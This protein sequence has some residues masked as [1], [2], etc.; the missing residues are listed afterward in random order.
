[1]KTFLLLIAAALVAAASAKSG[2]ESPLFKKHPKQYPVGP[3]PSAIAAA[4]LNDDTYPEIVTADTG[5]LTDSHEERPANDQVSL[6]VSRG[7]LEYEPQ[8]Q[9]GTGFAP[10][11]IAV[12]NFDALKARDIVVGC[13]H[14][15][16]NRDITLFRNLGGNLFEAHAFA[17]PTEGELVYKRMLDGDSAPIF[18]TPGITSLTV[19]ECP[20]SER[21]QR[22]SD[23]N[24]DGYRDVVAAA[25]SSDALVFLPGTAD[26]YL[27]TPAVI[28]APGGPRDVKAAD[29]DKDGEVDLAATLYSSGQAGLWKGDGAGGF[30][31]AAHFS[32]R[33]RLPH[34]L[35]IADVNLDGTLDIVVSHCYVDD[36]IV[37]FY[38][39]G[40]FEFSTSQELLLGED[41]EKLESEI[42]DLVVADLNGD[43]RPDI[44]AACYGSGE[45][46]VLINASSGTEKGQVFRKHVYGF[47]E[48]RPRAL[49]AADFNGDR[50]TDIAVALWDANAVAFLLAQ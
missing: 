7:A 24:H 35:Q 39:D 15:V 22:P 40:G 29:F 45:V 8:P 25:W 42:R 37:I 46:T 44:A 28:P 5:A 1:M 50:K 16:R 31:P 33:G 6:L 32:S 4:D 27:G 2:T 26:T 49:C 3:N 14:D 18:C 10:Y 17:V 9:L 12:A 41:R 34:K 43:G 36:S 47:K 48:G 19:P 13:F 23:A 20:P 21:S 11:A 30:E 38:G